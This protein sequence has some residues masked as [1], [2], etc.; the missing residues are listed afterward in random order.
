MPIKNLIFICLFTVLFSSCVSTTLVQKSNPSNQV[1]EKYSVLKNDNSTKSGKYEQYYKSKIITEGFYL[2]NQKHG[3]WKYHDISGNL[4]ITGN[5]KNGL[6]TGIW[7]TFLDGE[8]TS[9]LTYNDS[10]MNVIEYHSNKKI[11]YS[12]FNY[13]KSYS[14]GKSFH[15]NGSIKEIFYLKNGKLDSLYSLYFENG[16]LHREIIFKEGIVS[17]IR[18]TYNPNGNEINGGN[19]INGNGSFI[20]YYLPISVQTEKLVIESMMEFT[21]G[22][23]NNEFIR[24]FE[25]GGIESKGQYLN[26]KQI[27]IWQIYNSKNNLL[28]QRD[29]DKIPDKLYDENAKPNFNICLLNDNEFNREPQ[30]Q[31]GENEL[32]KFLSDNIVYPASAR[33]KGT[34]ERI[35]FDI[36][37]NEL[38]EVEDVKALS[39]KEEVLFHSGKSVIK[40]F[41][42]LNPRLQMGVPVPSKLT[43]PI[44]FSL[45]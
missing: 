14:Y 45:K 18:K 44:N 10:S 39:Y 12:I 17:S 5:Y 31:S 4:Y 8:K 11:A 38:G 2:N 34:E 40:T 25:D 16:Q 20:R 27:G 29:F 41:P 3:T 30:F 13:N 1:I 23:L 37:I 42:R 43:L 26:G 24:Y 28:E 33:I 21:N 15:K 35:I 32:Y 7:N 19:C 22:Y 36:Y 9:S 6:F